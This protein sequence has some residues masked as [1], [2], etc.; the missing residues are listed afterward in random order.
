MVATCPPALV[1]GM[2]VIIDL[3]PLVI[4]DMPAAEAAARAM[5]GMLP[6][7]FKLAKI[8]A[9]GVKLKSLSISTISCC[10]GWSRWSRMISG[11]SSSSC[12]CK[13]LMRVH[14]EG[15]AKGQRKIIVGAAAGRDRRPRN[16]RH[17]ILLPGRG[18]PVPMNEAR[19]ADLVLDP[20][21]KAVADTGGDALGAVRLADAVDRGRLAVDLDRPFNQAQHC[22]RRRR[23]RPPQP[24]PAL[25]LG[26]LPPRR[27]L[28]PIRRGVSALC[29]LLCE[30]AELYEAAPTRAAATSAGG[31]RAR[32]FIARGELC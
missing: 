31:C 13:S 29:F 12:S 10:P 21:P 16:A 26:G 30:V 9:G 3:A 18:E 25:H 23:R 15:A 2:P 17:A 11:A 22:R 27:G 20:H 32:R 24:P 14:P 7:F 1:P 8:S 6:P 19:S 5:P 28:T 4:F